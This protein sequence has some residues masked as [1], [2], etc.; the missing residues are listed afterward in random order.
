MSIYPTT[1]II[2]RKRH[3]DGTETWTEVY[4]DFSGVVRRRQ[5]KAEAWVNDKRTMCFCCSCG[6]HLDIY[7]RNHGFA[8]LR[9]CEVHE[10]AGEGDQDTGE[11]PKSVQAHRAWLEGRKP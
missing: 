3:E 11:M 9:P 8:G 7:C 1:D 10:M 4:N 5:V 6:D 2:D